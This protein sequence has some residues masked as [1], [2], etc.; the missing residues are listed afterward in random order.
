MQDIIMEKQNPI[1]KKIDKTTNRIKKD[2]DQLKE[3]IKKV[4]YILF[5]LHQIGVVSFLHSF[6]CLSGWSLLL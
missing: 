3:I 5:S 2:N 6:Y 1:E 4:Y